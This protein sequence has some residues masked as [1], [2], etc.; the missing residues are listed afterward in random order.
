MPLVVMSAA[1]TN[2]DC[3]GAL[4]A[5]D[6]NGKPLGPFT[7]DPRIAEVV[8]LHLEAILRLIED[9]APQLGSPKVQ[10]LLGALGRVTDY[11]TRGG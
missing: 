10:E 4:F 5:F 7:R 6:D 2:G 1:G 11:V 9:G 8:Q 3:H